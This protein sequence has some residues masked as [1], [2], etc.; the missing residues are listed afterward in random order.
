MIIQKKSQKITKNK[1]KSV[2]GTKLSYH[3]PLMIE[4]DMN[5]YQLII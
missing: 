5:I 3:L 1:I 2:N 4:V